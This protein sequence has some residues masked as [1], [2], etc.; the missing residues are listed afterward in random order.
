MHGVINSTL[1][2]LLQG[3]RDEKGD[4]K[5][6][7]VIVLNKARAENLEE[8]CEEVK[9]ALK[10]SN[11]QENIKEYLTKKEFKGG[12]LT[13]MTGNIEY[14]VKALKTGDLNT[15]VKNWEL[16][17]KLHNMMKIGD[18]YQ[19]LDDICAELEEITKFGNRSLLDKK[20][21]KLPT[22]DVYK[23]KLE[24]YLKEN[25]GLKSDEFIKETY[26]KLKHEKGDKAFNWQSKDYPAIAALFRKHNL[27]NKI[28]ENSAKFSLYELREIC[29]RNKIVFDNYSHLKINGPF[30]GFDKEG[31]PIAYQ[32]TSEEVTLAFKEG[33]IAI[34]ADPLKFAGYN[35][36]DLQ[37]VS[38][39]VGKSDDIINNPDYIYQ[40]Y[41]RLRGLDNTQQPFFRIITRKGVKLCFDVKNLIKANVTSLLFKARNQYN[42]GSLKTL[43]KETSEEIIQYISD[44]IDKGE[45]VNHEFCQDI[46]VKKLHDLHNKNDHDLDKTKKESS[47]VLQ[48]LEKKLNSYEK[49][50]KNQGKPSALY[51]VPYYIARTFSMAL[52]YLWTSPNYLIFC[53]ATIGK[54]K[55]KD[56][57]ASAE[58]TYVHIIKNYT[59]MGSIENQKTLDKLLKL[60]ENKDNLFETLINS[61]VG[62]KVLKKIISP[63]QDAHI[64]TILNSIDSENNKGNNNEENNKKVK[65]IRLLLD[66]VKN[67]GKI[68]T[69]RRI[70]NDILEISKEIVAAHAWYH[71]S[72]KIISAKDEPALKN[73]SKDKKVFHIRNVGNSTEFLLSAKDASM[74]SLKKNFGKLTLLFVVSTLIIYL[75]T[76]NPIVFIISAVIFLPLILYIF[77][78]PNIE[79]TEKRNHRKSYGSTGLQVFIFVIKWF[80]LLVVL[81]QV[82]YLFPE[83]ISL[84]ASSAISTF[85][86]IPFILFIFAY[87]EKFRSINFNKQID[88][89]NKLEYMANQAKTTDIETAAKTAKEVSN[90][91]HKVDPLSEDDII[92]GNGEFTCPVIK[93]YAEKKTQPNNTPSTCSSEASLYSPVRGFTALP[94]TA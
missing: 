53:L 87:P 75:F 78:H 80:P 41:G 85:G 32:Y 88:D 21:Y 9:N 38:L 36:L 14:V 13:E 52:Y 37:N 24:K 33:W 94:G 39:L 30:I 27:I 49:N 81:P 83:S 26:E 76:N 3:C 60:S 4:A 59:F 15:I 77:R 92:N 73:Y 63:L 16:D 25:F 12:L 46:I 1:L 22:Y 89:C 44:R 34:L 82:P 7:N 55:I 91:L 42:K 6:P 11:I 56:G 43:G 45:K 90:E 79:N 62:K 17:K 61:S 68:I 5:Y 19:V 28:N 84:F 31:K 93:H 64:L 8:L 72:N 74:I 10:D 29:Q 70:V 51:A 18:E 58:A 35:D 54:D 23:D 86:C 69:D 65:R 67:K 48:D 66:K 40:I 47:R 57:V 20:Q 71:D 2:A 50:I